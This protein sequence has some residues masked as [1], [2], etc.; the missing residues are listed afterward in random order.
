MI[1]VNKL[2]SIYRFLGVTMKKFFNE[3]H[4]GQVAVYWVA[5]SGKENIVEMLLSHPDCK[6][7]QPTKNGSY[8][9]LYAACK[10]NP[11]G[12][13]KQLLQKGANP[14]HVTKDGSILDIAIEKGL[15]NIVDL[16]KAAI[17]RKKKRMKEKEGEETS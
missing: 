14:E 3:Y 16:L 13:A 6:I 4:G 15:T 10:W 9:A 2:D 7:D 12:I 5:E 11:E 1:E 17:I 8:T